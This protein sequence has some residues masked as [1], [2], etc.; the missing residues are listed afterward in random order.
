MAWS[1]GIRFGSRPRACGQHARSIAGR[2]A[3]SKGAGPIRRSL[4]KPCPRLFWS[5]SSDTKVREVDHDAIIVKNRRLDI[6]ARGASRNREYGYP[7]AIEVA[8]REVCGVHELVVE[9]AGIS[10]IPDRARLARGHE[11]VPA[12]PFRRGLQASSL[13]NSFLIAL[14]LFLAFLFPLATFLLL[15][16]PRGA[17]GRGGLLARQH[18]RLVFGVRPRPLELSQSDH[19]RDQE[20]HGNAGDEHG[21][22]SASVARPVRRRSAV[23]DLVDRG[24]EPRCTGPVALLPRFIGVPAGRADLSHGAVGAWG[25][26]WGWRRRMC[27][28]LLAPRLAETNG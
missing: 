17:G 18:L 1:I 7:N 14:S 12:L 24:R 20:D 8:A 26:R 2:L 13:G 5:Q 11:V 16:F 19:C 4:Q 15:G 9:L 10:D 21:E 22:H 28:W 23:V 3:D 27:S 6:C 25:R